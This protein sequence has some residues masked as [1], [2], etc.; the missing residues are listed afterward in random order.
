MSNP[1][2]P[3]FGTSPPV[4][5]GRDHILHDVDNAIG[6]GPS[7]PDYTMFLIGNRGTGK[8]AVLNALE[9][10]AR[11]RDWMTI[12]ANAS[13]PGLLDRIEAD[14]VALF[15]NRGGNLRRSAARI[16]EGLERLW[17]FGLQPPPIPRGLRNVLVALGDALGKRDLGVLITIDELQSGNRHELR[18]LHRCSSM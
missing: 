15:R 16:R 1:F 8:T 13:N 4:L 9:E 5:A 7:H 11:K 6:V 18:E 2:S 17:I 3:S 12:S 10:R 14:A